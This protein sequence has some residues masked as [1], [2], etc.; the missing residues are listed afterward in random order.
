MTFESLPTINESIAT[1]RVDIVFEAEPPA[2]IGHAAGI[3]VLMAGVS[4]S[5][6]QE[7]IVPNDSE[8]RDPKGKKIAVLAGTSSHYGILKILE[9]W[10]VNP[11]K[12]II[13]D[14]APPDAKA[15]FSSGNVDAWA[16]WPPWVEQETVPGYAR[17]LPGGDAYIHSIMAIRKGFTQDHPDLT[18]AAL[19]VLEETKEWLVANPEEGIQILAKELDLPEEIVAAAWPKHDWRASIEADMLQD[20]QA[21]A[22]FLKN[23]ALVD[24]RVDVA[25]TFVWKP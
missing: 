12:V 4:C 9:A 8:I 20:I 10:G 18:R 11:E 5:L 17:A 7:L 23:Q 1:D 22:D 16:V 14:M 2:L 19:R 3:D 15:A 13:L 24:S 6:V 21:K 25:S